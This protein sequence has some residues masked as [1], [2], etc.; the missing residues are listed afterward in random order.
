MATIKINQKTKHAPVAKPYFFC[1]IPPSALW[2]S[3]I[4]LRQTKLKNV[5]DRQRWKKFI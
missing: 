3:W 2:Q 1:R 5:W 4:T